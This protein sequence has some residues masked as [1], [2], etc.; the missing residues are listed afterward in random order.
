M[1]TQLLT[2]A[3]AVVLVSI[4]RADTIVIRDAETGKIVAELDI[5]AKHPKFVHADKALTIER[6]APLMELRAR[7]LLLSKV[8]FK[9][10]SLDEIG[11]HLRRPTP[12]VCDPEEPPPA[13]INFV[14]I[15][16][17]KRNLRI[18]IHME[19]VSLYDLLSSLA[20]KYELTIT[21]DDHAI[22]VTDLKTQ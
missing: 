7:K 15:D 13:V 11:N 20:K 22:T 8:T 19:R 21:Y 4:A 5:D 1:R 12:Y 14:V 17:A 3:I 2:I 6:K 10:A 18:D 9:E 16:L